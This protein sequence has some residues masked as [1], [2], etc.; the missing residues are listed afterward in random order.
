[1]EI[2]LTSHCPRPYIWSKL[3]HNSSCINKHI[4]RM[5]G[6][7]F[8]DAC[9]A[10]DLDKV[11]GKAHQPLF[12]CWDSFCTFLK[13]FDHQM[14]WDF[15]S[16]S[17][18]IC[19]T[20]LVQDWSRVLMLMRQMNMVT[21]DSILQQSMDTWKWLRNLWWTIGY[22]IYLIIKFFSWKGCRSK[23]GSFG[24]WQL[25]SSSASCN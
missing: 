12:E 10:G 13:V 2:V 11:K 19:D 16:F 6:Y 22:N 25:L 14:S 3:T 8:R 9:E 20:I 7:D 18:M 15:H 5:S 4:F 21:L 24:V 23:V 17:E 1:M